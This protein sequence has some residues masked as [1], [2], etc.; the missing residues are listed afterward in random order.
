[1]YDRNIKDGR[2]NRAKFLCA[3]NFV[4]TQTIEYFNCSKAATKKI[5]KIFMKN[6]IG[7]L[8]WYATKYLFNTKGSNGE[9]E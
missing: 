2:G 4:L 1:M 7:K 8:K 5:I 6:E 3:T 9:I